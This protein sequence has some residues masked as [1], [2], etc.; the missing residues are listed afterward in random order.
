MDK[1]IGHHGAL[2]AQLRNLLTARCLAIFG[3]TVMWFLLLSSGLEQSSGNA[4]VIT[5]GT[6][7]LIT[8]ASFLRLTA[9]WEVR[10]L[11]FLAQ[12]GID[13]VGL[14]SLL[15]FSGGAYN[16]AVIYLFVPA[17]FAA[18]LLSPVLARSTILLSALAVVT[19]IFL[20]KTAPPFPTSPNALL[21][22]IWGVLVGSM[23]MVGWFAV[24]MLS[25]R[26]GQDEEWSEPVGD[27][28]EHLAAVARIA[29]GTA[30][31]LGT[32]LATMSALVEDLAQVAAQEKHREDFHLLAEQLEECGKVMDKLSRTARL[33]E[34]GEKRWIELAG[35]TEATVRHWLAQHPKADAEVTVSGEGESPR[36]QVDYALAQVI[37]YLLNNAAEISNDPIH[38]DVSWD[39]Y[40]GYIRVDDNGPGFPEELLGHGGKAV[41]TPGKSGLS[42]GLLISHATISR[43]NGQLELSNRSKGG[44]RA[45]IRIPLTE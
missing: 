24:D 39:G 4:F 12:L 45:R 25:T 42:V 20:H 10:E 23:V 3:L 13:I 19:L 37:E 11:E 34:S 5:L 22:G 16:P 21:I 9:A 32:P 35:F 30:E 8:V 33:N 38:V 43:Y 36:L 40:Y 2:G 44:A 26:K 6:L 28:Q 41:V 1:G 14:A 7:T 29:A 17:V 31:E 18:L 27:D 15:Y